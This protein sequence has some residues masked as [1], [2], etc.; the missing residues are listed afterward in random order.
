MAYEQFIADDLLG[1]YG[2]N[3]LQQCVKF[4]T[5]NPEQLVGLVPTDPVNADCVQ[6][7]CYT[8]CAFQGD[9]NAFL[10]DYPITINEGN[11][12]FALQKHNGTAF[13]D[14]ANP[15]SATEGVFSDL[16]TF[17]DYPSYAGFEIDWSLVYTNHGG[18]GNYRFVVITDDPADYLFSLPFELKEDTCDSKNTTFKM[19]ILN[20]GNYANFNYTEDNDRLIR[21]DLINLKWEDSVRYFGVIVKTET[22]T[23]D[24]KVNYADG[25]DLLVYAEDVDTYDIKI[26][27]ITQQLLQRFFRYGLR[28]ESSKLT[29]SNVKNQTFYDKLPIVT[30]GNYSFERLPRQQKVNTVSMPVK[31][32]VIDRY[33]K[34]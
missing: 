18:A 20:Q 28:T 19:E 24:T 11:A 30:N 1:F 6:E 9:K 32:K 14:V 13:I 33:K 4:K 17:A 15:M 7:P 10:Y 3:Q 5:A 34:S 12:V 26:P 29:D 8:L 21:Y 2:T 22:E 31:R 27:V 25:S 23:E 16:G